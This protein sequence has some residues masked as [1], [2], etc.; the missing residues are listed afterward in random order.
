MEAVDEVARIAEVPGPVGR[1]RQIHL[2]AAELEVRPRRAEQVVESDPGRLEHHLAVRRKSGRDDEEGHVLEEHA[3]HQEVHSDLAD[4]AGPD[5][6]GPL[7]G[8]LV[9]G[10]RVGILRSD[11]NRHRPVARSFEDRVVFAGQRLIPVVPKGA[12]EVVQLGPRFVA[13]R[14]AQAVLARKGGNC[15][16]GRGREKRRRD[17][18]GP[19]RYRD[20]GSPRHLATS[21]SARPGRDSRYFFG[22]KLKSTVTGFPGATVADAS[23]C[24]ITSC[25]ATTV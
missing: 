22:V 15:T 12:A 3:G 8:R 19:R 4:P 2:V 17:Q 6:L 14:A 24:P 20:P 11:A 1:E 7:V 10:L 23:F 25:Q 18:S 16:G 13:G 21:F 5:I 9:G